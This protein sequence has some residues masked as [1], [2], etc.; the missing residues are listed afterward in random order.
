MRDERADCQRGR[1]DQSEFGQRASGLPGTPVERQKASICGSA[2]AEQL[3]PWARRQPSERRAGVMLSS[4]DALQ[5]EV[6]DDGD[7]NGSQT[8][9]K[10][11]EIERGRMNNW[12]PSI[13]GA[14]HSTST[15][16][17]SAQVCGSARLEKSKGG[18]DVDRRL[19]LLRTEQ[20]MD[21]VQMEMKWFV[22]RRWRAMSCHVKELLLSKSSLLKFFFSIIFLYNFTRTKSRKEST[23]GKRPSDAKNANYSVIK[24]VA[25]AFAPNFH[26][27]NYIWILL[28]VQLH[29]LWCDRTEVL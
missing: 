13:C 26:W 6:A 19:R 23:P 22:R 11:V 10:D 15:S 27:A 2:A 24:N 3:C 1:G 4:A 14:C 9:L 29:C 18:A 20:Q 8:S 25:N 12:R 21:E 5:L 28:V 16:H 17:Q 7:A